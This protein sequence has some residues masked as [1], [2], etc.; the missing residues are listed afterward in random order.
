MQ[1]LFV[2]SL[3]AVRKAPGMLAAGACVPGLVPDPSPWVSGSG[4]ESGS[5]RESL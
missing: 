3:Q 5:A 4:G 1:K 2:L